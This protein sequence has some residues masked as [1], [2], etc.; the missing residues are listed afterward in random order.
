MKEENCSLLDVSDRVPIRS[1]MSFCWRG[2]V[3]DRFSIRVSS[4]NMQTPSDGQSVWSLV[5]TP[6]RSTLFGGYYEKIEFDYFE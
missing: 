5:V 1:Q 6:F 3:R 4:R 2:R